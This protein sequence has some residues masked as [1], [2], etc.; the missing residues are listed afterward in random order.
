MASIIQ[1]V[2]VAEKENEKKERKK[3]YKA[4]DYT[5]TWNF[6]VVAIQNKISS[7]LNGVFYL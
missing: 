1:K 7:K 4:K 5:L 6:I 3:E 2:V